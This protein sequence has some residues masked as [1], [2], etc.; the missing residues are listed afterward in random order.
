[1]PPASLN[2]TRAQRPFD[3]QLCFG[4]PRNSLY[5]LRLDL[6]L[7]THSTDQRIPALSESFREGVLEAE[8]LLLETLLRQS[9]ESDHGFNKVSCSE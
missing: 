2:T 5:D 3:P 4:H 8:P 1:M 7:L 9:V 6:H